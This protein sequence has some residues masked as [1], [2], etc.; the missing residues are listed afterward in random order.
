MKCPKCGSESQLTGP[1][2]G[3]RYGTEYR[4]YNNRVHNPEYTFVVHSKEAQED[5]D[6]ARAISKANADKIQKSKSQ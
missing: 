5:S 4:C 1:N 3:F 2:Y 6:K